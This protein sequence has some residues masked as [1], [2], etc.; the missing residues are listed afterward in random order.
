MR[1][2]RDSGDS[3]TNSSTDAEMSTS[4]VVTLNRNADASSVK[5]ISTAVMPA[6][7]RVIACEA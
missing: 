4:A 7:S 6:E 1:R 3:S 5:N 2:R